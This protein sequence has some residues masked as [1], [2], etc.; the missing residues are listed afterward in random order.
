MTTDKNVLESEVES[1]LVRYAESKGCLCLKLK[2]VSGRG[3]PDRLIITPRGVH[4]YAET[5]R[6]FGGALSPHQKK[7]HQELEL[8]RCHYASPATKKAAKTFVDELLK[9]EG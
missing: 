8:K 7:F 2:L 3:F 9:L 1:A 4:G 5:K 6:P